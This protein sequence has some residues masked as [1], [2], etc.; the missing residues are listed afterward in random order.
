MIQLAVGVDPGYAKCGLGVIARSAE[1]RWRC[2]HS[3]TVQTPPSIPFH[4]RLH[5]VYRALLEMPIDPWLRVKL[6]DCII[7]CE[8]QA[9]THEGK[10]RTGETH[11]EALKVQQVVGVVR[12]FAYDRGCRFVE[13]S[14]AQTKKVLVGI[15]NTATKEQVARAVRAVVNGCPEVMTEHAS[16]A[17]ANALAGARMVR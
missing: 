3:E 4:E 5:A 6:S 15:K 16:D 2:V 9:G 11:A 17:L 12:V 13:P 1:Q 10:R 7:A 8:E 14:P